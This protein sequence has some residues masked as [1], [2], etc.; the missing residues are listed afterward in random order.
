MV[1]RID[2]MPLNRRAFMRRVRPFAPRARIIGMDARPIRGALNYAAHMAGWKL[3][4][5]SL[6]EPALWYPGK[7]P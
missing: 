5:G 3:P 6:R 2:S 4:A 7:R 1:H